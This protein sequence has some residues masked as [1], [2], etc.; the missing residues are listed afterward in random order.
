MKVEN[1]SYHR[2]Y[3][4]LEKYEAGIVLTGAEVKS[5]KAGNIRLDTAFVKFYDDE[6][7]LVNAEVP[8]Y[9]FIPVE[10]YDSR[11]RRKLLL[12]RKEIIR[13]LTKIQSSP[14]LTVA[15]LSCYNKGRHIKLEVALSKG[16]R[17]IE[18]RKLE[19]DRDVERAEKK[20]AKE[21]EK[22]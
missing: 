4:E 14:S 1:R 12:H 9:K 7:Y 13:I 18:K 8:I 11:R 10:G 17:D 2:N 5:I 15:P 6:P 3:Q 20:E 21:F 16:R 19:K 22:S